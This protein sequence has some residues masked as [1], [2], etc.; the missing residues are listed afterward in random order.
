[1]T[2][3]IVIEALR[4]CM[5]A[6]EQLPS[7]PEI[8]ETGIVL[9]VGDGIIRVKGLADVRLGEL[10]S[11]PGNTRGIVLDMGEDVGIILL[12]EVPELH[13]GGRVLRT[14]SVARVPVGE[15]LLGRVIDPLG[16]PLDDQGPIITDRAYPLERAATAI[17]DRAP[18]QNPV[19]TGI[20]TIDA[21]VPIG[22]G[23]RQLIVGDRQTG[24]TSI[25]I[26]TII[27]QKE[28]NMIVVYLAV[29]QR[30]AATAQVISRLRTHGAMDY[31][32]VMVA[33]AS[34]PAGSQFLAPYAATSVGEY[35]MEQGH[36]VLVV[37]DDLTKHA[38]TY[39]ELSLLLR[40]PPGREAYPGDIFY[41]HSR[42]LERATR[43][44]PELGGGSL[45]ALPIVE[46]QAQNI[47]A[48]IPTNII[49]ITDGQIYLN[50]QMFQQGMLPAV[51]VRLSVSRVGGKAQLPAYQS[52]V[53]KL[54]LAYSQFQE[55]EMFA[56]ISTR[57]D[58]KSQQAIDRGHRLR[59]LLKQDLNE[60]VPVAQQL[61]LLLALT[62]G[63]F[64]SV[65]VDRVRATEAAIRLKVAEKGELAESIA[66]GQRLGEEM[67]EEL[68]GLAR[69]VVEELEG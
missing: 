3:Q 26:D 52:V 35:F 30:D 64:D 39:R 14:H 62:E 21:L 42:L 51:D 9:S 53:G 27:N 28:E 7:M 24:K 45:T 23:Q 54:R 38:N 58:T 8:Q 68:L 10:V 65:P 31:S 63:V 13:A 17:L 48:Y 43:L 22:R 33:S 4:A 19:Q 12:D 11:L 2:E 37:Y 69:A 55:L 20:K 29:G 18:V 15:G 67:R 34:T 32:V 56:R 60:P 47:S 61:V 57:L 6:A 59:E 50:P 49:S 66:G 36:D 25:A 5:E 46:T 44:K 41:V 40:R 1:M 16:R